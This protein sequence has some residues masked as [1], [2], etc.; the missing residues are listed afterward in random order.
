[1][2]PCNLT[3]CCAAMVAGH[4]AQAGALPGAVAAAAARRAHL[5][6]VEHNA[7]D[8]DQ[9]RVAGRLGV[10][11]ANDDGG[12]GHV[13]LRGHDDDGLPLLLWEPHQPGGQRVHEQEDEVQDD[14]SKGCSSTTGHRERWSNVVNEMRRVA[15]DVGC[16]ENTSST[17][18]SGYTHNTAVRD[19]AACCQQ[20]GVR[21]PASTTS[22]ASCSTST[23]RAALS[24]CQT[25]MVICRRCAWQHGLHLM[26]L[27]CPGQGGGRGDTT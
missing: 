23:S 11:V 3:A 9:A 4:S 5:H 2:R 17:L 25:M 14:G 1:M 7:G 27:P 22:P 19:A 15:A 18:R 10:E 24:F 8:R 6:D 16:R 26:H 13:L 20:A 21:L 12:C